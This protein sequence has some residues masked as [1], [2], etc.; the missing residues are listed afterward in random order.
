MPDSLFLILILGLQNI[1]VGTKSCKF[2]PILSSIALQ[3]NQYSQ[4]FL[5]S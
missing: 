4:T 3:K 5:G 1:P 2:R